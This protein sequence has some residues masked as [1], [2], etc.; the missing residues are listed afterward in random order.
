MRWLK[1]IFGLGRPGAPE[2]PDGPSFTIEE[3]PYSL[4]PF[5]YVSSGLEEWSAGNYDRAERLLSQAVEAYRR[6]EPDGVDF[7]LGRLGAYLVD[8]GRIDEA[9]VALDEAVTRGTVI[10]A[11]LVDYLGITARRRDVDALFD[12]ASRWHHNSP[13]TPRPWDALL[14]CARKADREGDSEFAGQVAERVASMSRE[15]GDRPI[16]WAATGVLGHILERSGQ[17]DNAIYLWTAA[18]NEG[19]D[20]SITLNRLSMHRERARDYTGAIAIIKEALVRD[21]P[22]NTKEQLRKRLER[23]ESRTEGR[24]QRDVP[25]YTVRVGGDAVLPVFHSRVTP[26]IRLTQVQGSS[27]RCFGVNRGIG[28]IVDVSLTDGKEISRYSD[29]PAFR[30]IRF[31]PDGYGLGTV[32][33]GRVGSGETML[34]FL[35]PDLKHLATTRVSDAISDFAAASDLWY[36]G[37]RDGRLYAFLNTGE[38]LWD[39]ETPGSRDHDRDVYSRPCPYHV[40]SDGQQAVISTMGDIYCISS[41]GATNWHFQLPNDTSAVISSPVTESALA[42]DTKVE[43]SAGDIEEEDAPLFNLPVSILGME[44]TVSHLCAT[45][46]SV[47]VGSSD[48][49]VLILS[50]TGQPL[51]AHDLAG[52]STR[53]V[54]DTDGNL[55]AACT[56]DRIFRWEQ[57]HFRHIAKVGNPPNGIGTWAGGPYIWDQKRVDVLTWTGELVYSVEFSKN[58]SNAMVHDGR[59]VCAAGVLAT[60]DLRI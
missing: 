4:R 27:V 50:T 56:G 11:I 14:A 18:F 47:F 54:N 52:D 38:L 24:S 36:V 29:L 49:R 43:S 60:F 53:V 32:Q 39:W 40:A 12:I 59:L 16:S 41:G 3:G 35:S 10:P 57:D 28:A 45:R 7:A 55:V 58:V 21:L 42:S 23:C 30:S 34:T 25:S 31:S 26:P 1:R 44:P 6:N 37:C 5:N 51:G 48:G 15:V 2:T 13:H 22:P 17:L 19:S 33:T 8:R 46:E 9:V 20:D